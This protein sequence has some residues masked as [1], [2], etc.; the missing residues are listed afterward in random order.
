M[1]G[2]IIAGVI[3]IGFCII[4]NKVKKLK[5]NEKSIYQHALNDQRKL[6]DEINKLQT[7]ALK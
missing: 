3:F 7:G 4:L 2:W 1:L 5:R 6:K